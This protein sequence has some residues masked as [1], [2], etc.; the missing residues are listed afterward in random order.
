MTH[1]S[2]I[3]SI[4]TS[5]AL[6]LEINKLRLQLRE[7]Q[8]SL[9]AICGGQVDA[10]LV[11]GP[12][13][14]LTYT[15]KGADESYR[16]MVE[17][18]SEGA[19]IFLPDGQ[20]LYANTRLAEFLKLP[21]ERVIGAAMQGF[22]APQERLHFVTQLTQSGTTPGHWQTTLQAADASSLPV[23]LST[24]A[25]QYHE[26]QAI[27]AVVTDLS[28]ISDAMQALRQS[29]DK[30]K[31]L[32]DH[33]TI[34][35]SMTS[36]FTGE[37]RVNQALCDM[38]GYTMEELQ[39][40]R[41]Q[42]ITHADDL[43]LTQREIERLLAGERET[44]RF[45]KRYLHKNGAVVWVDLSA[46]LRRDEAGAPLYLINNMIDITERKLAQTQLEHANRA[47]AIFSTV[48]HHLLHASDEAQLLQSICQ[49]I[50]RLHSYSMGWV[51][52]V[53]HDEAKSIRVV[54]RTE[55]E[56]G[57]VELAHITWGP[58]ARGMGPT[59]RAIRS[60]Q[61][62]VCQD[63]S[64]DESYL[65]WRD[66]AL[67]RGYRSLISLPLVDGDSKQVF[68][69]FNLYADEVHA[70]DPVEIALL[71]QMAEDLAFGA[72]AIRMR[73]ER[74]QGIL[75]NLQ[76]IKQLQDSLEDT[77]R[78]ISRLVELRDPYT[79][80]HQNRVAQLASAIAT[81]IGLPDD[82]IHAIHI[83]GVVHDLGKIHIPAEI[84]SKPGKISAIEY[85]LIKTHAQAG[86]DILKGIEFPWPIAQIVLQHHE[87]FDGTGYPAGIQGDAILLEARILAVAD[88]VEAMCLHRPY[89]AG[90]GVE[91]TLS[92]IEKGS[93][94][95]FDPQVV[96]ACLTLFREKA[97]VFAKS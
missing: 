80:G 8:E 23:H 27:V 25:F 68:G 21:L 76:Q 43:A 92:E 16:V 58:A 18:M 3:S 36:P 40:L 62:Q 14:Q 73:G 88:V 57:F 97:F 84:L 6:Q 48:N 91:E 4:T 66:E 61:A 30:F 31:Y 83:A 69:V 74:D 72:G 60:G 85:E 82:Q 94:K 33:S 63:I 24:R 79:A 17:T 28:A 38:L 2:T 1:R 67:Q 37:I 19:A 96:Q 54:A 39:G 10:L 55:H 53:L 65:L 64:H 86:F 5:R 12:A 32:F 22:I 52:Y 7:A 56:E 35:K 75:R 87:R 26:Q 11:P 15:L 34:G 81:E 71:E 46:A 9:S 13:G 20:I 59:G 44:V 70:F 95:E 77:V 90:L 51:G 47:L 41:W 50:V 93:G 78:A 45:N 42:D 49:D 89:R 29:E